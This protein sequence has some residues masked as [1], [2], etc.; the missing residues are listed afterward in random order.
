MVGLLAGMVEAGARDGLFQGIH[1]RLA[2]EVMVQAVTRVV[3]RNLL[4]QTGLTLSQ[5]FGELHNLCLHGLIKPTGAAQAETERSGETEH[6]R[7][8]NLLAFR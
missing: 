6:R 5:A 4:T 1:P 8:I 7:G 2:A 3:D